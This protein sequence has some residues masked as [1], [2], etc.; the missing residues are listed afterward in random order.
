[1]TREKANQLINKIKLRKQKINSFMR[2]ICQEAI[3]GKHFKDVNYKQLTED[4]SNVHPYIKILFKDYPDIEYK[5]S[6]SV[7]NEHINCQIFQEKDGI[8]RKAIVRNY[9]VEHIIYIIKTSVEEE[10]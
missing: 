1:M 4:I 8:I 2:K 3:V 10:E 7:G 9:H 5:N 6:Q